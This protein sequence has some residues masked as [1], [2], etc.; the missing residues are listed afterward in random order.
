[1][2]KIN[3][4]HSDFKGLQFVISAVAKR[5]PAHREW[6][7]LHVTGGCVEGTDGA[8]L[9]RYQLTG[10]ELSS[11]SYEVVKKSR[12]EV[13]L[14]LTDGESLRVSTEKC[15][16]DVE[17]TPL[18]EY[19]Y[20]EVPFAGVIRAL[21]DGHSMQYT[22]FVDIMAGGATHFACQGYARPI[23]FEG[24]GVKAIVMPIVVDR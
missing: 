21:P 11:G 6:Q 19:E 24:P 15:F 23:I 14:A 22:Y 3:N 20:V 5:D 17:M 7:F 16:P 13:I 8:R 10:Q 1:M 18:A 4:K 12:T 9:H 2:I